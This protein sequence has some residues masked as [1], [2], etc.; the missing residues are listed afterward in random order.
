MARPG[1]R[2]LLAW[3]AGAGLGLR[4]AN[5]ADGDGFDFIALGDMPYGPD[6]LAGP[7]YRRLMGGESHA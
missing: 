5:A 1:R 3:L 6:L 2:A 4:P 7:L